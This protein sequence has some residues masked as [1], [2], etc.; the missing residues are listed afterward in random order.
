MNHSIVSPPPIYSRLSAPGLC[1]RASDSGKLASEQHPIVGAG[2]TCNSLLIRTK[3]MC[4]D[5]NN[6][7]IP[8]PHPTPVPDKPLPPA[9]AT[10]VV[11]ATPQQ[12]RPDRKIQRFRQPEWIHFC[13]DG[14]NYPEGDQRPNGYRSRNR[15]ASF[16]FRRSSRFIWEIP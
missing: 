1:C 13:Q 12:P 6:N 9:P 11:V 7:G 16:L 14:K 8:A 2:L 3:K 5:D 4:V 10:P 15:L